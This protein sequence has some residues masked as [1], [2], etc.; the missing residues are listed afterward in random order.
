MTSGLRY[1]GDPWLRE[2]A[3]E[4]TVFDDSLRDLA[5]TMI[6]IMRAKDGIGLAAQQIGETRDLCVVHVPETSDTDEFGTRL[7]PQVNMPMV[8]VNPR[9]ARTCDRV[10]SA[11]EGCLS[12]PDITAPISRPAEIDLEYQDMSGTAHAAHL[13]GLVARAVQHEMDHLQGV[14]IVDR[15]TPVKKLALSGR[16][17][18]LRRATQESLESRPD[19]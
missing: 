19:A 5:M 16:L 2:K 17:K 9:I 14:L 3:R 4:V 10:E 1:Y 11:E 15:M 13:R 12:F 6:E 8:L 18:R 7:N